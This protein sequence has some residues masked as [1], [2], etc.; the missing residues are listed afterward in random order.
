[1][2]RAAGKDSRGRREMEQKRG[3]RYVDN[4]SWAVGMFSLLSVLISFCFY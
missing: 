2:A 4:I 1:M 3:P